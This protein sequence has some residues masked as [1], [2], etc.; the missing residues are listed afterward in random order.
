MRLAFGLLWFVKCWRFGW[1]R[2]PMKRYTHLVLAL[3]ERRW[4]FDEPLLFFC[5]PPFLTS[6]NKLGYFFLKEPM[7]CIYHHKLSFFLI[8]R[9]GG[10]PMLF[11]LK[12]E[13]KNICFTNELKKKQK[14]INER[15]K[16]FFLNEYQMFQFSNHATPFFFAEAT[17]A[18]KKKTKFIKKKEKKGIEG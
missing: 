5:V 11:F 3:L 4:H 14:F 7:T 12:K 9:Q 18:Y 17:I 10:Y 1:R 8:L 15:P 2:G 16:W 13:K 6:C